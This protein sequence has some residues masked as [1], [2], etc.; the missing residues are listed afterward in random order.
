MSTRVIEAKDLCK[1]YPGGA[2]AL[3]DVSFALDEGQT[4]ALLGHNG[5]GKSTLIKLVLGLISPSGGIS[6]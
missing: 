2:F 3:R 6:G 4:M 1:A 5:A